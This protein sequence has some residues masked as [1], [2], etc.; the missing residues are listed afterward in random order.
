MAAHRGKFITFSTYIRKEKS[1]SNDLKFYLRK[2]EKGKENNNNRNNKN[3][4]KNH[5]N[6]KPTNNREN[7]ASQNLILWKDQQNV[8]TPS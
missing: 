5:Q 4:S 1:K 6:K 2:L 7:E 8:Q 3:E